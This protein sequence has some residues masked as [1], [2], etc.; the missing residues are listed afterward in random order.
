MIYEFILED[1]MPLK[2]CERVHGKGNIIAGSATVTHVTFRG[3]QTIK[4]NG[5]KA[6]I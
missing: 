4:G 5:K 2:E 3:G 6:D 1:F